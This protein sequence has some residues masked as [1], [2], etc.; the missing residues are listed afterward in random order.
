MNGLKNIFG[1][2]INGVAT[3]YFVF[4]GLIDWPSAALIS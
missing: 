4:A 1:S 3:I 2:V